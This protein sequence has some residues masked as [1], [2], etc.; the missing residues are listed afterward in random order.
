MANPKN[1]WQLF[2]DTAGQYPKKTAFLYKNSG[3]YVP[4]T[5]EEAHHDIC[6]LATAF[7]S[8]GLGTGERI[9]ILSE[10]RPEWAMTDLAAQMIG[11]ISVPIYTSLTSTE[12]QYILS[13]SGAKILAVSNKTLFEKIPPIQKSLNDLKAV[14]AFD[15]SVALSE[16]TLTVPVHFMKDL[17]KTSYDK[18]AT[19]KCLADIGP[20]NTATII[21]TSGTTG[22]PK[23][24]M[25]T[26]SNFIH[27]VVSCKETLKM[28]ETD[29]H[30]SFLPLSHVFE[31]TAGYYLMVY[32]GAVIGY[33]E[34]MDTVP[35]NL[36]EIK[37]T[38]IL[39]VPRFYEK[40]RERVLDA[41]EKA[42]SVKKGI[43]YWAKALGAERRAAN[44]NHK[45]LGIWKNLELK[46]ARILA[47]KKFGDRLGGRIRFCISGGAPLSKEVA[48]FF[49]DLGVMIYEGYG[50]TE[51]SPV[52]AV[53]REEKFKFG[54][55][56]VPLKEVQVRIS[57]EGEILTKGPC[58]MKGYFNK[59]DETAQ[60]LRDGW[61]YTGDLGIIDKDGFLAIT[62]RKKELIVTS[63]G[64]KV[65]PRAVEEVMEQDPLILRCVLFGEAKKFV[66][67]L[68]V[69]AKEKI[70]E[71]AKEQKIAY[72]DYK[73]LLENPKIYQKVESV[74]EERSKNLANFEKI[75]YFVLLENDFTQS[76]GEL[77]PTLKVKRDVVL[78]RYRDKLL[79]L[80][81]REKA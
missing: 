25:L 20:E 79:A 60:A 72:Q 40:I 13:D 61:F 18:A 57:D 12:I 58:V 30:L 47:Y 26:H 19:E 55:V 76:A 48:E 39:G 77:T 64:K 69:P 28:G 10:N 29:V 52:I 49:C 78:S 15:G 44:F 51:T 33:A 54:T 7:L 16:S 59:P 71:I 68:I 50:L 41:V 70:M 31:R 81:D 62:G 67:A 53:N 21:Y 17:K 9:A 66:T 4:V 24:V 8:M 2:S 38:F 45:V 14:I 22:L 37:P 46:L 43:F 65:V 75:K 27:N 35:E 56:G 6:A 34:N 63:G 32:I 80:Y 1:L 74:I 73:S 23:G 11:A 36:L 3:K 42:S 5:W